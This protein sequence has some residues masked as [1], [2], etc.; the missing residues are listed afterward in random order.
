[1]AEPQAQL[2]LRF[3]NVIGGILRCR[4][5]R[6]HGPGVGIHSLERL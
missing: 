1:M 5:L 2:Q 3:G 6:E 4:D